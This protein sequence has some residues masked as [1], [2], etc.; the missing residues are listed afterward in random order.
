MTPEVRLSPDG[1]VVAIR[2]EV[3][4][5][6]PWRGSDGRRY[7]DS[8]VANWTPLAPARHVERVTC[9]WCRRDGCALDDKGR[10]RWHFGNGPDYTSRCPGVRCRPS[11]F[12]SV[13]R[14]EA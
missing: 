3:P 6:R 5:G 13:S 4:F 14:S 8:Q 2:V 11:D 9:P 12:P 7:F 10:I 1:T